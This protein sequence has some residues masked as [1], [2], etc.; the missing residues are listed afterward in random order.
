[1]RDQSVY[2]PK[3]LPINLVAMATVDGRHVTYSAGDLTLRLCVARWRRRRR[4]QLSVRGADTTSTACRCATPPPASG[5]PTCACRSTRGA[6]AAAVVS[7]F[8]RS[9][10]SGASTLF[11]GGVLGSLTLRSMSDLTLLHRVRLNARIECIVPIERF[12]IIGTQDG[13]VVLLPR[14]DRRALN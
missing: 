13:N 10:T 1:M 6:R 2:H 8:A 14:D 5:S 3:A 9:L 11:C 7:P 4:R 12:V